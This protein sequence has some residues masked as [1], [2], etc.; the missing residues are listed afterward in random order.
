MK[1][2]RT[3]A[4]VVAGPPAVGEHTEAILAEFLALGP[5]EVARLRAAGA[6]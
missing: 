3:A 4:H 6:I 1:L 2:S 5:R